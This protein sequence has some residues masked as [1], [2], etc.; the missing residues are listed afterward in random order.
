MIYIS[1]RTS[2][3]NLAVLS[4]VVIQGIIAVSQGIG[5]NGKTWE[6]LRSASNSMT[7]SSMVSVLMSR[8]P[9]PGKKA[10]SRSRRSMCCGSAS[11]P[12]CSPPAQGV[13]GT[14]QFH[15]I[16]GVII[17]PQ[18]GAWKTCYQCGFT[19]CALWAI[20]CISRI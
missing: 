3:T 7:M 12:L 13:E 16:G 8:G 11:P 6:A 18:K 4:Y 10:F 2:A 20:G 1:N 14:Q 17:A 5:P 15:V 9:G 19:V